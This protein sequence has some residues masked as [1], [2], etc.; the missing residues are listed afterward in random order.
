[1]ETIIFK[2]VKGSLMESL[3]NNEYDLINIRYYKLKNKENYSPDAVNTYEIKVRHNEN[4]DPKKLLKKGIKKILFENAFSQGKEEILNDI[5]TNVV[6]K[7]ITCFSDLHDFLDANS[8]GG[9]C[10]NEYQNSKDF[11]LE[12]KVQIELD[13]W[14]KSDEFKELTKDL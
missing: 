11:K 9:F 12:N 2:K 1:M 8:Y 7:N 5:K 4:E 14:I 3:F 6:P 13:N 10:E